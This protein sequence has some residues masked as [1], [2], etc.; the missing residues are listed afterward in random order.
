VQTVIFGSTQT[1]V[2]LAEDP[3]GE[4]ADLAAAAG[5]RGRRGEGAR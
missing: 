4:E 5:G 2:A 3:V 1:G